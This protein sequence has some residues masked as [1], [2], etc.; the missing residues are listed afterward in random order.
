MLAKSIKN[1]RLV[2]IENVASL[3]LIYIR[4]LTKI[5]INGVKISVKNPRKIIWLGVR[6]G[7]PHR[8]QFNDK[9]FDG[10]EVSPVI[11]N[12]PNPARS[13]IPLRRTPPLS[14]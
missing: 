12:N 1:T 11:H 7:S 2:N 14:R 5:L 9:T 4:T 6:N 3:S 13:S 10:H 8:I